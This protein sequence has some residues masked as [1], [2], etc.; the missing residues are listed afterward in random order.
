M[1]E[2]K[3]AFDWQNAL[4]KTYQD[5]ALQFVEHIPHILGAVILL[6][7]GWIIASLLRIL[8]RKVMRALDLLFIKAAQKKG[9]QD[10]GHRSY[11][12]VAGDI[13]FWS[14]LI[15]FIAAS[16]HMLEMQ[17]F[18][19]LTS[20]LFV[21]LPNVITGLMIILF[22][23]ALSGITRSS[24]ASATLSAGISQSELLARIAQIT[25]VVTAIVIGVEQLGINVAFI[26]STLVVTAGV[27]LAGASLAFGLG[28]KYFIANLIGSQTTRKH[29]H[30]GQK[31]RFGEIEGYIL[32]ITSSMIVVDTQQG[33]ATIPAHLVQR[34]I[35]EI[36]DQSDSA[37]SSLNDDFNNSGDDDERS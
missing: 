2:T 13:V 17:I 35:C 4:V 32:D 9:V 31:I 12:K 11:S 34:S 30:I 19:K 14:M 20:A 21:Y 8:T 37:S 16:G 5:V 27:L 22:G 28:A 6:A 15:F 7:A 29:Y 3:Q 36:L 1:E 23:F 10:T 26:S 24:I 25:V 18:S 33:R